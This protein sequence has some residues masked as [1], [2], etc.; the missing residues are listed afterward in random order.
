MGIYDRDYM[1]RRPEPP[2]ISLGLLLGIAAAVAL[3][4][5]GVIYLSRSGDHPTSQHRKAAHASTSRERS[6]AAA[7]SKPTPFEPIN[8]NTATAEQL[9]RIPYLRSDTRQA[10]IENRPYST[11]ED[12]MRVPGIKQ[13]TLERIR[14]YVTVE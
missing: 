10:I 5:G 2:T 13:R 6:G 1:R 9:A 4:L 7:S 3:L 14:S 12:L 8:V 11:P